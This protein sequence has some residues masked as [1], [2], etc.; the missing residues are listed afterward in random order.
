MRLGY[1]LIFVSI[2]LMIWASS[3]RANKPPDLPCVFN[4]LCTCSSGLPDNYGSV[5]CANVPFLAIPE[6]LNLSKVYTL[7]SEVVLQKM[8]I[9]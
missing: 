3:V 9:A 5:R 2:G 6:A 1:T 7:V 4:S 8:K